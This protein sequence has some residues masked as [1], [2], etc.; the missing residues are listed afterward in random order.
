MSELKLGFS[1]PWSVRLP[2]VTRFLDER[3]VEEFFS[4]G[5]LRLSTFSA[6]RNHKDEERCDPNEGRINAEI[7]TPNANHHVL[8]I[9]GQEAYILCVGL[10]EN[11]SMEASFSTQFGIRILNPLAFVDAVSGRIPGFVGGYQGN[12]IYRRYAH[13]NEYRFIWFAQGYETRELYIDCPEA[14]QFCQKYE[15][16]S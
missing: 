14:R 3:Y 16:V 7:N 15:L 1:R 5:R 13:Q 11:P 10:V 12:C 4:L 6:F 8:A 2:T 9:N